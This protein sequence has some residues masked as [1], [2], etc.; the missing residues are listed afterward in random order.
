M[1]LRRGR[2]SAIK[3]TD[4]EDGTADISTTVGGFTFKFRRGADGRLRTVGQQ[5]AEA[6][7]GRLSDQAYARERIVASLGAI[8]A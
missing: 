5:V 4:N 1:T 3:L 2:P 8:P 7:V 6:D